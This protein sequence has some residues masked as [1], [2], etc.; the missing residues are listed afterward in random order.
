MN[1]LRVSGV[2]VAV[3]FAG[4]NAIWA[5]D[6]PDAGAPVAEVAGFYRDTADRIV[7]GASLS[8]LAIAALVWFA[9][10]LRDRLA[11]S[12]RVLAT[13]AFGGG[14]LVAAAGLGAETINMAAALRAR[15]GRAERRPGPVAVR[16]LAD[17]RVGGV[18][19]GARRA[20]AGHRGRGPAHRRRPAA[21]DRRRPW[22]SS[23]SC[24]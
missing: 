17:P 6:M 1:A 22:R 10:A 4:G 18:G 20:R 12:D 7:V 3:L 8:L 24:S 15:D 23:A 13:T 19:G 16:G 5:L 11:A 2:A 14:I 9:A 21:L